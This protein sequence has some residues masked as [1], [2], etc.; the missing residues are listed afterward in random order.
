MLDEFVLS[1]QVS[2]PLIFG[3]I[4]KMLSLIMIINQSNKTGLIESSSLVRLPNI[5][6]HHNL[7]VTVT[8]IHHVFYN[9]GCC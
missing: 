8:P 9:A 5:Y 6:I 7:P 4:Q 2:A 1:E 3:Y